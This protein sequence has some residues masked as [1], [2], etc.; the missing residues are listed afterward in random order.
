ML[1]VSN[2]KPIGLGQASQLLCTCWR[3]LLCAHGGNKAALCPNEPMDTSC[4]WEGGET[5][6]VV[7][8]PS[9][10]KVQLQLWFG[11]K[12]PHAQLRILR[13]SFDDIL[14]PYKI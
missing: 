4:R 11:P 7:A 9:F 5:E 13:V 3:T 2:S 6:K 12:L 10:H 1:E 8:E 14:S